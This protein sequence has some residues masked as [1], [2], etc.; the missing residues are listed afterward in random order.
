MVTKIQSVTNRPVRGN[1]AIRAYKVTEDVPGGNPTPV[2]KITDADLVENGG[3]FRVSGNDAIEMFVYEAT[4][5]TPFGGSAI[6]IYIVNDSGGGVPNAPT[7]LTATAI[8]SSEIDLSW[9]DN[10][11][12]ETGFKIYRDLV[13]IDTVPANQT[14]YSDTGLDSSTEYS[15]YVV[16]TN[17][18]GDSNP[19]NTDTATTDFVGAYDAIP[20]L[21]HV[22]EPARR[23][24]SSYGA[25]DPLVRIRRSSDNAEQD[26]GSV[27]N[28]NLDIVAIATF[29]GAGTGFIVTVYDQVGANNPTQA[30]AAS[31][32]AY[33]A[34]GQNSKPI[35]RLDG[36][37]DLLQ[38]AFSG[39]LSQPYSLYFAAEIDATDV[40][41]NA[42]HAFVSSDDATNVML[43]Y[44]S[45]TG[46]PDV[47]TINASVALNGG[48]ADANF[49]VWSIL[50]N[51]ASSQF[52]LNGISEGLGNAGTNNADG[53]TIG[54]HYNGAF[55]LLG[56]IAMIAIADP[57]HD[58]T[59]RG[60]M[61]TAINS[62]WSAF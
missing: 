56:N 20:D 14:T 12:D 35:T 30:T 3:T 22:Y 29:V 45:N 49:N 38:T 15:Y 34:N 13:L 5:E 2:I 24:L 59:E 50:F 53:I 31:Q 18:S 16:A 46:S 61:Q 9:T 41:D 33:I 48:A 26:F 37:D 25:N 28:G 36:M 43:A 60:A 11:G 21:V 6:P 8:S 40:N 54:A 62:F 7:N 23:T 58:N 42:I 10:S 39:A 19:S 4:N 27:T 1:V 52:W 55:P 32:P 17:A 47:W 44:K 57:S 51:G